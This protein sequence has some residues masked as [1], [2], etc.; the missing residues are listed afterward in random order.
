MTGKSS[1]L[2][3]FNPPYARH[4]KVMS[5][6]PG[7]EWPRLS[8]FAAPVVFGGWFLAFG[9]LGIPRI[10]AVPPAVRPPVNL[11]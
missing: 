3:K 11:E 6:W 2:E 8:G 7:S 10:S 4:A 5:K 1:G 9:T